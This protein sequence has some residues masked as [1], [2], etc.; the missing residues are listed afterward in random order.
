MNSISNKID[1]YYKIKQI[2]FPI[3]QVFELKQNF[4]E[5]ATPELSLK[6]LLKSRNKNE[7]KHLQ[8]YFEGIRELGL[9]QSSLSEFDMPFIKIENISE[10]QWEHLNYKVKDEDDTL[11]FLCRDFHVNIID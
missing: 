3:I 4:T 6:I 5:G 8:L 9:K 1:E 2:D 11:S 7:K 10:L